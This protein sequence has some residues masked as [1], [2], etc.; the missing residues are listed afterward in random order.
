MSNYLHK[1]YAYSLFGDG[2]KSFSKKYITLM[3][4]HV[5]TDK[6]LCEDLRSSTS[7]FV[8]CS[9]TNTIVTFF[10]AHA[11]IIK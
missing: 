4:D 11:T 5:F 2:L 3:G 9:N 1:K 8:V 6:I 10:T 7:V